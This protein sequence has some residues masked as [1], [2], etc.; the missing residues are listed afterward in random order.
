MALLLA[1]ALVFAV[2]RFRSRR[3][4][5]QLCQ[6]GIVGAVLLCAAT[7]NAGVIVHYNFDGQVID[8]TG[9]G[10]D[11]VIVGSP[12]FQQ[13]E[14]D[15]GLYFNNPFGPATQYV[16]V[17]YSADIQALQSGSF[18][19]GVRYL[20]QETTTTNGRLLG[21]SPGVNM[22]YSSHA[23][24]H[25]ANAGVSHAAGVL[26][27]ED[28]SNPQAYTKDGDYHWQ[29]LVVDRSTQQAALWLD[30]VF[31][32]S[33]ALD[34]TYDFVFDGFRVGATAGGGTT[35]YYAAK[36]TVIDE[37]VMWDTALLATEVA[38]V[39]QNGPSTV[40]EP[41]S[42]ALLLGGALVFGVRRFRSRRLR[43]QLCQLG[44]VGA[45]LLCA[46]VV[47]AGVIHTATYNGHTYHLLD[48]DGTKW[49]LEAEAEAVSLGGHLVTINDAAENQWV[50]DTFGGV[51]TTYAA[52]NSLPDQSV[53]SLWIGFS[54]H[55]TE[56]TF[57]WSSGEAVTYTNWRSN[58]PAGN[59]ADED[60]VGMFVNNNPTLWHDI[61]GTD[62]FTDLTFGVVEINSI[63]PEPSSMALLLSGALV[64]GVRRLRSRRAR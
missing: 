25:Y 8:Q 10:N 62:R 30:D 5:K 38:S 19:I 13:A 24:P 61:V 60:F 55:V 37:F 7:V 40:P 23:N 57:V 49:W 18:T 51:A 17:P 43:Q 50:Y 11:G 32:D 6:L 21:V 15:Q 9:R 54:D 53:L 45:V 36:E 63:V 52:A 12:S 35:T 34:P 4:R 48:T 3:A 26:V 33:G 39:V 29:L 46:G 31:I 2:R 16:N 1:G 44:I 47:N 59:A 42:V 22:S 41:S 56:G 28:P 14:S 58:E 20:N 27:L 64:F